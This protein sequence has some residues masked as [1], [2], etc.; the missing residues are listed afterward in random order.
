[1]AQKKKLPPFVITAACV[2]VVGLLLATLVPHIRKDPLLG[3]IIIVVCTVGCVFILHQSV[4][5]I[6]TKL[7]K[8]GRQVLKSRRSSA[9]KDS[10]N[11]TFSRNRQRLIHLG[12]TTFTIGV[13][14][15]AIIRILQLALSIAGF[16]SLDRWLYI[17]L[18]VAAILALAGF[19]LVRFST[20]T[21]RR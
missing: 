7:L 17:P 8:E 3:E 19:C 11:S 16:D 4:L 1:M 14:F 13:A 9:G 2:L 6:D 18:C 10:A 12:R 20:K 21:R 5:N 15:S